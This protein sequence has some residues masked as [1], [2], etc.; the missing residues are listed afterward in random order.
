MDVTSLSRKYVSIKLLQILN[1][2]K[3]EGGCQFFSID[4]GRLGKLP[5]DW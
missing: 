4:G 1:I 5:G 3:P 2:L